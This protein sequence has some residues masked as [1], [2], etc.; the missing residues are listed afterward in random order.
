M[1][2]TLI[3]M[4]FVYL[5]PLNISNYGKGNLWPDPE[6]EVSGQRSVP[7]VPPHPS[8][9]MHVMTPCVLHVTYPFGTVPLLSSSC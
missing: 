2:Q 6:S 8:Y 9:F 3:A 1:S 4:T 7:Q 5:E